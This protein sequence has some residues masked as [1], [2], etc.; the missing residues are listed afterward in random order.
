MANHVLDHYRL[1]LESRRNVVRLAFLQSLERW[2]NAHSAFK[3]EKKRLNVLWQQWRLEIQ[4]LGKTQKDHWPPPSSHVEPPS[5][6]FR[7]D[8]KKMTSLIVSGLAQTA[9]GRSLFARDIRDMR[10]SGSG[11]L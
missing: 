10:A 2:K 11:A 6:L 1:D 3:K 9:L 5:E 4:A 8:T 7:V